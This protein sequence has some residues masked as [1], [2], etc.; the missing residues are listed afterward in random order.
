MSVKLTIGSAVYNVDPRLLR[1]HVE[2]IL[3]QLTDETELLLIDDGSADACGALC[4]AYAARSSRVRYIPMGE[5]RGLSSVRNRTIDEARGEWIFFADGDDLLSDH[6]VETALTFSGCD[7]EILLHDRLK[8]L[9]D[10]GADPACAVDA[11]IPLPADAGRALSLSILCL[12]PFDPAAYG[13]GKHAFYHAAWGALYRKSFLERHALRFPPEVKKAQDSVFNGE[14][15]FRAEKIAYLP[16]VMYYYRNNPQGITKRFSP[17]YESLIRPLIAA[18]RACLQRLFPGDPQVEALYADNRIISFVLD[19]V[20]LNFCHPDN[21]KPRRQR[22]KELYAFVDTAPFRRAVE[23][24]DLTR[25]DRPAWVV[26]IRLLR[27]RWF[28]ALDLSQKSARAFA[29][30]RKVDRRL[31]SRRSV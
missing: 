7:C 21:K 28:A 6:F 1:A 18:Q 19:A 31:N 15:Y 10:K 12:A 11:P 2:G 13:L 3:R 20:R 9:D 26:L 24:F 5:N 23:A 4:R 27:R 29:F 22:K 8:F 14:A 25:R 17:D 16:Y 30:F